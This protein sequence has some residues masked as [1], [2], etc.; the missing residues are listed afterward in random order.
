[1]SAMPRPGGFTLTELLFAM[2]VLAI[3]SGMCA[4][5]LQD[6]L[7]RGGLRAATLHVA[8]ALA[9]ARAA[10][11]SGNLRGT[12]CLAG[13]G[14]DC[15]ESPAPA[16]GWLVLVGEP[17]GQRV[18]ARGALPHGVLLVSNRPSVHFWPASLAGSTATLTICDG[19]GRAPWRQF[20]VSQTGRVRPQS[21]SGPAGCP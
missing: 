14:G 7:R 9:Q 2:A 4:P 18:I 10:S 21:G 5:A 3:V 6:T 8:G 13:S 1:M 15:L 20:V 16:A 12:F 17:G 19:A 11:I